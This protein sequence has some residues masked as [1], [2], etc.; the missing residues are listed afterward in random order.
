MHSDTMRLTDQLGYSICLFY[1]QGFHPYSRCMKAQKLEL[2]QFLNNNNVF[3]AKYNYYSILLPPH[4]SIYFVWCSCKTTLFSLS[5]ENVLTHTFLFGKC[6]YTYILKFCLVSKNP[7][8]LS[9]M[10]TVNLTVWSTVHVRNSSGTRVQP[11][12][13]LIGSIER[14]RWGLPKSISLKFWIVVFVELWPFSR[15]GGFWLR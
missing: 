12:S 7:K 8:E 6:A 10:S 4:R 5:V 14:S 13:I 9:I 11:N 2:P 3:I 15:L 1:G